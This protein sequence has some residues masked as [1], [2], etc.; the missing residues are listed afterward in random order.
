LIGNERFD[1]K[2]MPKEIIHQVSLQVLSEDE[3][4][5]EEKTLM[6]KAKEAMLNAHA[7]YSNFLVGAAVLL[8][9][10]KIFAANNQ[11]NVSYPVGICAE[12]VVLS[13]ALAN[14]PTSTP[15]KIAI[16]AKG[17]EKANFAA[18]TP[19]GMCRQ[20]INEYEF[21]F[22]R[23]IEILMLNPKG[24]ILRASGIDQL[25]PFKFSDLNA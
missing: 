14:Y 7:P 13:F 11:E 21:K 8:D 6:G 17:R 3:W 15:L 2:L 16:V 19:C 4:S 10:G 22:K 1:F 24:E 23:P 20:T 18:V 5:Q 25:L 9:N 12:R